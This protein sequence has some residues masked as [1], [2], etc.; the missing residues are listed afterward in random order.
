MPSMEG[1]MEAGLADLSRRA[2]NAGL[3]IIEQRPLQN[4]R[5]SY[6]AIG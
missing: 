6:I 2:K 3:E 1:E 4:R 5:V